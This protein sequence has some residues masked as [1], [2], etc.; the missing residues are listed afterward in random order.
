MIL[1]LRPVPNGLSPTAPFYLVVT[2]FQSGRIR[3]AS[4]SW[5][6]LSALPFCWAV[7]EYTGLIGLLI[8]AA[9]V[10][11]LGMWSIKQYLSHADTPDP[12]EVVIDEVL[13]MAL[14]FTA[15]PTHR[16]W[17]IFFGFV[18]FRLLDSLKPFPIGWC[19]RHI[20]GPLGVM[21]DDVAAG[22]IAAGLLLAVQILA[23]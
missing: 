7:K 8:F 18:V 14:L 23:M 2:W 1:R 3:P 19:D 21:M 11:G 5:G 22:V 12:S 16:N 13:G 9:L 4:G 20:K 17:W 6:S 10:M 15:L